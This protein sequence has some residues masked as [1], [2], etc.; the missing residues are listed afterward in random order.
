MLPCTAIVQIEPAGGGDLSQEDQAV[1]LCQS[2]S[3]FQ[4]EAAS[5][6]SYLYYVRVQ[7]GRHVP[8]RTK[9][10]WK[11]RLSKGVVKIYATVL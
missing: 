10:A 3:E 7:A 11:R 5:S 4:S 8:V 1:F 6:I 9:H 2:E